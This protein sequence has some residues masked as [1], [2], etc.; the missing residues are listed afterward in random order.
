M[1]SC[2]DSK[3]SFKDALLRFL[4]GDEAQPLHEQKAVRALLQEQVNK[5]FNDLA[6]STMQLSKTLKELKK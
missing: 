3:V 5:E 6:I 4:K 1:I 2:G